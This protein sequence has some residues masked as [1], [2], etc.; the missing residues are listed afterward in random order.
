MGVGDDPDSLSRRPQTVSNPEESLLRIP[1]ER[2]RYR[3]SGSHCCIRRAMDGIDVRCSSVIVRVDTIS[4]G[5]I[6]L[7]VK[8]IT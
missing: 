6:A 5:G 2:C 8:K 3:E 7:N 1:Q 4:Q